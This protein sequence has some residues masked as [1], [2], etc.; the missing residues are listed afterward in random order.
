MMVFHLE[1]GMRCWRENAP[2]LPDNSA[3]IETGRRYDWKC[4]VNQQPRLRRG[5]SETTLSPHL[6]F[7]PAL[8]LFGI[9]PTRV[10]GTER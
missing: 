7:K 10:G 9:N 4:S 2:V 3:V 8:F 6:A 5:G 1:R